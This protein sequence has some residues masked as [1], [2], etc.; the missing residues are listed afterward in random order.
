MWGEAYINKFFKYAIPTLLSD[1][2]LPS[3]TAKRSCTFHIVTSQN[4]L[5]LLRN[6]YYLQALSKYLKVNVYPSDIENVPGD[7]YSQ[8]TTAHH[9]LCKI[10]AGT[11]CYAVFLS[12]DALI[13]NGA[14]SYFDQTIRSDK[15]AIV[16]IG[17]RVS[18]E[19]LPNQNFSNIESRDLISLVFE[20]THPELRAF[21]VNEN[22]IYYDP[23]FFVWSYKTAWIIH[24]LYALPTVVAMSNANPDTLGRAIEVGNFVSTA[25]PNRDL[26]EL[27]C[28]SDLAALVGVSPHNDSPPIPMM[29]P[30]FHNIRGRVFKSDINDLHRSY[31]T[32]PILVHSDSLSEDIPNKMQ[33]T[34]NFIRDVLN[35]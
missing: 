22:E 29:A 10:H 2:N 9:F 5:G 26:I 14:L 35:A 15:Q 19:K 13:S 1:R 11:D 25:I 7:K 17:L 8:M 4:D 16:M 20:Y 31:L 18:E 30:T 33:V 27:V 21:I 34:S 23:G 3:I 28:D 6:S 32:K 24:A 12:P